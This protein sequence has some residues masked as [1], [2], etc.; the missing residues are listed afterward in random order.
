MLQV[1]TKAKA[2][3]GADPPVQALREKIKGHYAKNFLSRKSA[4]DPLTRGASAEANF[5]L[6]QPHKVFGQRE[7][8]L[9][10]ITLK[11]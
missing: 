11:P 10:E 7:F 4:K 3:A 8:A 1:P 9:R 5:R 2:F 6:Q